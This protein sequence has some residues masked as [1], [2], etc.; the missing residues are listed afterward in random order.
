M[1]L[2]HDFSSNPFRYK[3]TRAGDS[4]LLL[5]CVL[6]LCYKHLNHDTGTCTAEAMT[7]KSAA[8]QLLAEI[9][10]GERDGYAMLSSGFLDAILILMTLSVGPY[11]SGISTAQSD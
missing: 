6:A 7:H 1:P 5:H 9:E 11:V 2:T 10:K 3:P 4:Q 8:L